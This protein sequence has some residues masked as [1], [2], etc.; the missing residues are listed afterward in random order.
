MKTPN[1]QGRRTHASA[2]ARLRRL[3]GALVPH[4]GAHPG[5][6]LHR[7]FQSHI[8]PNLRKIHSIQPTKGVLTLE[9]RSMQ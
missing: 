8:P 5:A 1:L 4:Q 3:H 7:F 2:L 9:V 6:P